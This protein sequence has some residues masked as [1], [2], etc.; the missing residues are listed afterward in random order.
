[1][2]Q[3]L[4]EAMLK[5]RASAEEFALSAF[6]RLYFLVGAIVGILDGFLSIFWQLLDLIKGKLPVL[7][8]KK[9]LGPRLPS[10]CADSCAA[11]KLIV[12]NVIAV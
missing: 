3:K 12:G 6:T 11:L 1:M 9:V 8:P 2:D 7:S 4:K 10:A 5:A